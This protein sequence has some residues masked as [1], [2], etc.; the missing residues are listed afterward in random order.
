MIRWLSS[1]TFHCCD[2]LFV[3]FVHKQNLLHYKIKM[4]DYIWEVMCYSPMVTIGGNN[5]PYA[6]LVTVKK[7][8]ICIKKLAQ[9]MRIEWFCQHIR[10]K[11]GCYDLQYCGTSFQK[12]TT[13]FGTPH[14]EGESS[15]YIYIYIYIY[16]WPM[17]FKLRV[18]IIIVL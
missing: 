9:W 18:L 2:H 14:G 12:I 1:K 17:H 13:P 16:I 15:I 4:V 8:I 10:S 7:S 5:R 11:D 6:L 3:I